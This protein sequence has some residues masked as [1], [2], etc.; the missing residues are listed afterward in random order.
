MI[1]VGVVLLILSA[2]LTAGIA[3]FNDETSN[4]SAFGVSLTNVSIGGLF[5]TGVITGVVGALGIGLAL[6]G[7]A[8]TRHKR[9]NA[10]R[11]V[12][13]ARSE[14]ETLTEEN[15]RL[16]D[17]LERERTAGVHGATARDGQADDVG[18]GRTDQ[19]REREEPA[20]DRRG[21]RLS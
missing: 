3:L 20:A 8:R 6:V 16:Q 4:A 17:Q 18:A 7:S 15:A 19:G 2:L 5:L 11:Q 12:T 1:V 14:A 10:K 21:G 13:S 9:V